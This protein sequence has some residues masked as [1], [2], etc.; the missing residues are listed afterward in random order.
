LH[1]D[2]DEDLSDFL[3][4]ERSRA[5]YGF[6]I[7]V[8]GPT[9]RVDTLLG[10]EPSLFDRFFPMPAAGPHPRDW[11][12]ECRSQII[13]R[14][15]GLL[16][17]VL[18]LPDGWGAY[19]TR[20]ELL[21]FSEGE[22]SD[23]DLA[24]PGRVSLRLLNFDGT[25]IPGPAERRLI[26]D[27]LDTPDAPRCCVLLGE[28]GDGKSFLTYSLARLLLRRFCDA[29]E[30]GVVPLRL[31]LRDYGPYS[32][33]QFLQARLDQFGANVQGWWEIKRRYRTLVILDGFDEFSM[34]LDPQ[35]VSDNITKLLKCC[36]DP[37]FGGARL[38]ITSRLHFFESR[39]ADRLL[40]RLGRPYV[41][42]LAGIP[43][44]E[45]RARLWQGVESPEQRTLLERIETMHDP[46]GLASKPLFFQMVKAT[47]RD[48]PQDP[49]EAVIYDRYVRQGLRR[50]QEMLDDPQAETDPDENPERMLSF[51]GR[52]A[53]ALRL[54]RSYV[55]LTA[56]ATQLGF[57]PAKLLWDLSA[58]DQHEPRVGTARADSQAAD[59]VRSDAE[60]RLRDLREEHSAI[61]TDLG[62]ALGNAERVRLDRQRAS[63]ETES[64]EIEARLQGEST[65]HSPN[66]LDQDALARVG[67]RSLLTRVESGDASGEWRVNFCHRSMWE[68]FLSRCLVERL[69][70]G[71]DA[72]VDWLQQ[73]PV[74]FEI[75]FFAGRILRRR[76][77]G[78]AIGQLLSVLERSTPTSDPDGFAGKALTLLAGLSP[79]LPEGFDYRGRNYSQAELEDADLSG[80]D[81]SGSLFQGA[82]LSNAD[83]SGADLSHCDLTGV[84]LHETTAVCAIT[85][86]PQGEAILAAYEDG[87]IWEWDLPSGARPDYRI[88]FSEPGLR[89]SRLGCA[90]G[91]LV[92]ACA[93]RWLLFFD[94]SADHWKC[95]ARIPL[96]QWVSDFTVGESILSVLG[97]DGGPACRVIELET[98]DVVMRVPMPE[99]SVFA[100][101]DQ[102]LLVH[103]LDDNRVRLVAGKG[104]AG[105]GCEI[106][107]RNATSAAIRAVALDEV[108]V[109]LGQADGQ[110]RLV[111]IRPDQPAGRAEETFAAPVHQ[112]PV[113]SLLFL[114]PETLVSGGGDRVIVVTRLPGRTGAVPRGPTLQRSLRCKGLR[115]NGLFPDAQRELLARMIARA[116]SGPIEH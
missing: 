55:S 6:D 48:L 37:V 89:I 23:F 113:T 104:Y 50:K 68:Y 75:L 18:S 25:E 103:R 95:M 80:C 13:T 87:S 90:P 63:I 56:L 42:R 114:D 60:R 26:D 20:P 67:T 109:G 31:A 45:A 32:P 40:K 88:R 35:T 98:M 17:P 59:W 99:S 77:T 8:W 54:T 28:F 111:R 22:R 106:H 44:P 41:Y 105:L 12:E 4:G 1:A 76:D 108:L 70:Q 107:C 11:S 79:K 85:A 27:W 61:I 30:T 115:I 10:L 72:V 24:Y 7:Q 9:M 21:C 81:F 116:E 5:R 94:A 16:R 92:W 97:I 57:G 65:P 110:V 53:E 14:F 91:R 84:R 3:Q 49:D 34:E 2:P 82:N 64:R 47:L 15:A 86:A 112:G 58:G 71:P 52:L 43:R 36:G 46:L 96:A 93:G 69:D 74:N 66:R 100:A 33:P 102:G 62:M 39:D 83:L 51:L 19:V 73:G 29:P 38:L 101:A 78:L